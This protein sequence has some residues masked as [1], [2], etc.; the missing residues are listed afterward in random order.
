MIDSFAPVNPAL[1][2]TPS[3]EIAQTNGGHA[4]YPEA[5]RMGDTSDVLKQMCGSASREFPKVLWRE[6]KDW[7]DVARENDRNKTWPVN[8]CDRYTNQSPTHECT[9]HSLATNF[10]IRWNTQ[11]GIIFPDGP[12]VDFRYE[13]SGRFGSFWPSVMSVYAE[14]NPS[15]WGG[16]N[17]RTVMSIAIRRGFLPDKIQPRDYGFK[18]TLQGTAGRGGKNQSSGPWTRVSGFPAGWEETAKHFRILEVIFPE[19]AEQIMCLVLAGYAVCVGRNGHAVPYSLANVNEKRIGYI[20]S[21]DVIRWDSWNTVRSAVGGAYAIASV[22]M[23]SDR[24]K[25]AG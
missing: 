2:D 5:L 15:Q 14:A 11:L 21:Y 19:T 23:P 9:T 12:K 7:P 4:G 17:I 8:R 24:M 13:E 16:A 18:H 20:D 6:P 25:P 10:V 3:P 1:I 22:T